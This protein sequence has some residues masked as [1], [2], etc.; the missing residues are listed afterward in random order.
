[1]AKGRRAH[2]AAV[3]SLLY[4]P[5]AGISLMPKVGGLGWRGWAVVVEDL[6]PAS[7]LL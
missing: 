3:W 5:P 4:N 2:R 1:M 7:G 6:A